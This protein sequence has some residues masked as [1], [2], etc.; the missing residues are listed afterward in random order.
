L[1]QGY[2]SDR[3]QRYRS[4]LGER[5]RGSCVLPI[6]QVCC[7]CRP[8]IRPRI[9]HDPERRPHSVIAQSRLKE[10]NEALNSTCSSGPRG[11]VSCQGVGP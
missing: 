1:S 10:I 5:A 6:H 4:D 8:A 7:H 2:L 11:A 9:V 3:S